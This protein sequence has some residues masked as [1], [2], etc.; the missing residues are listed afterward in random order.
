MTLSEKEL[1]SVGLDA[2]RAVNFNGKLKNTGGYLLKHKP[3]CYGVA[4]KW[5]INLKK[6]T[7]EQ[8]G[9]KYNGSTGQN[10]NHMINRTDKSRFF[11]EEIEQ[12]CKVLRV[13]KSYFMELSR[14]IEELMEE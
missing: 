3:C 6:M 10:I 1:K 13:K 4:L 2:I 14:K 9:Q 5:L 8:F 7:Y 11:I 12:M